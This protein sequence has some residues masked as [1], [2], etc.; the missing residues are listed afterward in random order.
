MRIKKD[1][2][3]VGQTIRFTK[4]KDF[5]YVKALNAGGTGKT[6]LMRDTTINKMFVCKKYD[7]QQKEYEDEFFWKICRRD[8]NNVFS[9]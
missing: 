1:K 8:K 7:P 2:M 6:I 5:E 4:P 9:V 3:E